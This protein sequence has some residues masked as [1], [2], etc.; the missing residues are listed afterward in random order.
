MVT[1]WRPGR[2]HYSLLRLATANWRR[3]FTVTKEDCG[4]FRGSSRRPQLNGSRCI[5]TIRPAARGVAR[6]VAQPEWACS[7]A[8]ER[9]FGTRRCPGKVSIMKPAASAPAILLL[10]AAF[11]IAGCGDSNKYAAP[12]PPKV[13]VATPAERDIT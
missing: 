2:R 12:P 13:T 7:T 3:L 5:D 9:K 8:H 4:E 1:D 10:V 6:G 11:A